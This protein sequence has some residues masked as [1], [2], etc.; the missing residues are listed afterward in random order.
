[1]KVKFFNNTT[2][3]EQGDFIVP[4]SNVSGFD[5]STHHGANSTAMVS[6]ESNL[7]VLVDGAKYVL[8]VSNEPSETETQYAELTGYEAKT[9]G[10]YQGTWQMVTKPEEPSDPE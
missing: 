5:V 8:D 4:P 6:D 1:M 3:M 9:G 2:G 10:G 7:E